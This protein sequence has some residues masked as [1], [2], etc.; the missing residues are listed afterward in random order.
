MAMAI[1]AVVLALVYTTFH[2]SMMVMADMGEK[3]ETIQQGRMILERMA[4][5][6]RGAFLSRQVD[7]GRGFRYGFVGRSSQERE[8]FRDRLDFITSSDPQALEEGGDLR[9]V[10]YFLEHAPGA[11]GLTLF[12]R[13]DQGV[14]GDLLR[15]GRA[16]ALCERVRSL[17]YIFFDRL[18]KEQKEW[19]SLEGTFRGKLPLRVEIQLKLE[20]ARGRVHLFGTQVFVPLAGEAG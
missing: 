4:Q 19:S 9:E 20:D 6:L 14:D 1:L 12:R 8:E 5:D 2:Q 10:G 3:A 13:Q 17:H 15:G 11:K 16:I 7:A 18:G